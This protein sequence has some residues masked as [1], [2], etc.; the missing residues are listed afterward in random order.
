MVG[1]ISDEQR[2]MGITMCYKRIST[3]GLKGIYM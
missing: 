3:V 2:A 1:S